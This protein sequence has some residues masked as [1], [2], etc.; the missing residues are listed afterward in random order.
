MSQR[1][2]GGHTTGGTESRIG[3]MLRRIRLAYGLSLRTL[4]TRAGFSPS[5]L[6]QVETAQVSPSIESLE[7]ITAELG[8]TLASLFEASQA[9]VPTVIKVGTRPGF[10]SS[11]SRARVESLTPVRKRCLLEALSVA[12]APRGAS[13]ASA[14][15]H[16]TDQFA[17]V[18]KGILTLFLDDDSHLLNAGDTVLIPRKVPH[19]WK[20]DGT[21]AAE[22][23]LVSTRLAH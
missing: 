14:V 8:V 11:W 13:G 20:N 18:V 12:L 4:A 5:F 9:Q 16:P 3:E 22:M 1:A 17:Y 7:R 19:R 21:A 2:P 15:A 23:V 6:S 10:T